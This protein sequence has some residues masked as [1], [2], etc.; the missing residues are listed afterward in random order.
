MDNYRCTLEMSNSL[1][2]FFRWCR[3]IAEDEVWLSLLTK[4]AT[5]YFLYHSSGCF[6]SWMAVL[7]D[8]H[9]CQERNKR[10]LPGKCEN[11]VTM[12]PVNMFSVGGKL[13]KLLDMILLL[14]RSELTASSAWPWSRWASFLQSS[15]WTPDW[16]SP[17]TP[18]SLIRKQNLLSFENR[19]L[20]KMDSSRQVGL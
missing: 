4:L 8:S 12:R 13:V 1:L 17:S 10:E 15:H 5:C 7:S 16:R 6:Q 2:C 19:Q 9:M 18:P 20:V 14:L 3:W 11:I